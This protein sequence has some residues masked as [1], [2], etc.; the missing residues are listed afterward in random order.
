MFY[1]ILDNF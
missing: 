1:N